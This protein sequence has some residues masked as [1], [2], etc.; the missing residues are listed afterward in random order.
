MPQEPAKP[1]TATDV[2]D[3]QP[4][5]ATDPVDAKPDAD[6]PVPRSVFLSRLKERD[7]TITQVSTQLAE[8]QAKFDAT[9]GKAQDAEQTVTTLHELVKAGDQRFHDYVRETESKTAIM[10]QGIT[11][12]E[13]VDVVLYKYGKQPEATRPA[14]ADWLVGEGK[15]DRHIAMLLAAAK[16]APRGS[17]NGGT[18]DAGNTAKS[19][20]QEFL[21]RDHSYKVSPEGQKH[22][23]DIQS[24][25]T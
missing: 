10:S 3:A 8:L 18:I 23:A 13:D 7:N 9:N 6:G 22:F 5:T 2:A 12:P 1:D 14:L 25:M 21:A 19:E 15:E 20:M 16:P 24:R 17:V 11:D 4:D